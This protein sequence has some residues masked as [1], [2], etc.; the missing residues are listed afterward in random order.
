MGK[1]WLPRTLVRWKEPHRLTR[2]RVERGL[3]TWS[4][5]SRA[6]LVAL[7][8]ILL[9]PPLY[10]RS[11]LSGRPPLILATFFEV[12]ALAVLLVLGAPWLYKHLPTVVRITDRGISVSSGSTE[13]VPFESIRRA[14]FGTRVVDG[15]RIRTLVI[16][17]VKEQ[18]IEVGIESTVEISQLEELLRSEGVCV[19]GERST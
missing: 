9:L 12:L 10:L 6:G 8:V 14:F 3:K 2:W 19:E 7:A 18:R 4:F 17:T 13:T 16:D 5:K 15:Y 1:R 11:Y